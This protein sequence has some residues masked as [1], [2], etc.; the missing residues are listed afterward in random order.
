MDETVKADGR[1]LYTCSDTAYCDERQ[2]GR[3]TPRW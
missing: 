3:E 2:A 1:K